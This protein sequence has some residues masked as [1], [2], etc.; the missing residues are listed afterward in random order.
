MVACNYAPFTL[1][2]MAGP[3]GPICFQPQCAG[4]RFVSETERSVIPHQGFELYGQQVA[5]GHTINPMGRVFPHILLNFVLRQRGYRH[6]D[7]R[8]LLVQL[9]SS[10]PKR[11][12][13]NQTSSCVFCTWPVAQGEKDTP[14][15]SV[16]TMELERERE[17]RRKRPGTVIITQS[18]L[19]LAKLLP[20]VALKLVLNRGICARCTEYTALH[21]PTFMA[22]FTSINLTY[23]ALGARA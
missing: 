18:K 20:W 13:L 11:S 8:R 22:Q 17:A 6:G 19:V 21:I 3:G 14:G 10:H 9:S 2:G 15:Y 23:Q 1:T 5:L 16:Q 12:E 7:K 4:L